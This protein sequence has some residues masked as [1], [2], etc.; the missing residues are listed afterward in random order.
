MLNNERSM[1]DTL[2]IVFQD[3]KPY[4]VVNLPIVGNDGN[5]INSEHK[6]WKLAIANKLLIINPEAV[7]GLHGF[8]FIN[9]S[10]K[11]HLPKDGAPYLWPGTFEVVDKPPVLV[12]A[13]YVCQE[14]AI[15]LILP[16]KEKTPQPEQSEEFY[17]ITI[18]KCPCGDKVCN[19][20]FI[21]WTSSDGR[22]T[23]KQAKLIQSLVK[24]LKSYLNK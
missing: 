6:D 4:G 17:P 11:H 7:Q 10:D 16:M 8:V 24:W 9:G 15:K 20:Y 23:E 2:H 22:L 5:P 21:N 13:T 12:S 19:S 18:K 3:G 1:K 14:Q